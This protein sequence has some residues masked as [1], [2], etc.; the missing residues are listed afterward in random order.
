MAKITGGPPCYATNQ[1]PWNNVR[2]A[3]NWPSVPLHPDY[4]EKKHPHAEVLGQ[5]PRRRISHSG[6][7]P[8]LRLGRRDGVPGGPRRTGARS[9]RRAGGRR[10][11]SHAHARHADRHVYGCTTCDGNAHAN[12]YRHPAAHPGA[13]AHPDLH[14]HPNA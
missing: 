5:R 13:D 9:E 3:A 6:G 10:A 8:Q 14:R 1:Q 12:L 4:L 7:L 2:N 11:A